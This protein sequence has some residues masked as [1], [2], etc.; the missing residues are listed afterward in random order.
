MGFFGNNLPVCCDFVKGQCASCLSIAEMITVLLRR[1]GSRLSLINEVHCKKGWI[2]TTL[3]TLV[4]VVSCVMVD[5]GYEYE[6]IRRSGGL[7]EVLRVC[8][9]ND[10]R[11]MNGFGPLAS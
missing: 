5:H 8:G 1:E 11:Y 7:K 3:A 4:W 9:D 6:D 10:D 2:P